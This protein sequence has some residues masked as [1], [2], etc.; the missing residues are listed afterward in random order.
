M[1]W[2]SSGE[3]GQYLPTGA[4]QTMYNGQR[5]NDVMT[6]QA[7]LQAAQGAAP[8]SSAANSKAS[9]LITDMY[10]GP[11]WTAL[12]RM[13]AGGQPMQDL[14]QQHFDP[15]VQARTWSP[16]VIGGLLGEQAAQQGLVEQQFLS[17][18]P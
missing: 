3:G 1:A 2:E 14:I 18:G 9:G 17:G 8:Y 5:I 13:G 11:L 6:P 12:A 10:G 7:L 16:D 15:W 4:M